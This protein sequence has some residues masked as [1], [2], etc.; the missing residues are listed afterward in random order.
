MGMKSRI[1]PAAIGVAMASCAP[2]SCSQDDQPMEIHWEIRSLERH[3]IPPTYVELPE[4]TIAIPVS[5]AA[6]DDLD[7]LI[8]A[9]E[10]YYPRWDPE[11]ETIEQYLE[12]YENSQEQ[13]RL[14]G[15]AAL[16]QRRPHWDA[17]QKEMY[18][19]FGSKGH[20]VSYAVPPHLY[21]PS[22]Q[23]VL[24]ADITPSGSRYKCM[25]FRMSHLAPVYDYY[26]ST[27][28]SRGRQLSWSLTPGP[29]VSD[30]AA[31]IEVI[32]AKHFPGY[33]RLDP[34]LGKTPL[35]H[36][37]VDAHMPALSE[38]HPW[39]RKATLV[40]ALFDDSRNWASDE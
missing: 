13:A 33:Q 16:A 22:Y 20:F 9:I 10:P 28:G 36:Y 15:V 32:I 8:A 7:A 24:K 11:R 17:F 1:A 3:E 39:F 19:T 21:I 38:P 18:D 14:R 34:E 23:I 31:E 30:L 25:V 40:D 2:G 5:Q 26:E 27:V 6:A 35:P 4:P 37:G 12:R 29:E